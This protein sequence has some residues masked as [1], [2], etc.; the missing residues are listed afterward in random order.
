MKENYSYRLE[1]SKKGLLRYISHLDLL[2]LFQR[3]VRRAEIPVVF[4]QGFHPIPKIKFERALKL[5]VESESEKL[6]LRLY[7]PLAP[8]ELVTRLNSQLPPGIQIQKVSKLSN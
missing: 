1:F 8:E 4:S 3:A 2:R 5:G 7:I 6:F